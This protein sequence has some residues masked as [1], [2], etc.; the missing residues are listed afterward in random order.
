MRRVIAM[1][2]LRW[3]SS[4]LGCCGRWCSEAGVGGGR[5][6]RPGG[7]QQLPRRLRRRPR[8]PALTRSRPSP[9]SSPA[10]GTASSGT[11]TSPTRTTRACGR[12]P[13]SRRSLLDGA[14][15]LLPDAVGGRR[16]VPGRQDRRPRQ[17]ADAGTHVFEIR[18]SIPGVLDP[19]THRRRQDTS[20]R[21]PVSR[22]HRRR[23]SSGTS[24][25]RR[26]TTRSSGPTSRSRCP[27]TVT[28]RGSARSASASVGPAAT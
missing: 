24:S 5:R 23:R 19:G 18:Y 26:G 15:R 2:D 21:P 10:A 13:R 11:G 25:H 9:A 6:R 20:P 12:S 4:R 22:H 27:A 7:V 28:G 16:P 3:R 14:A 1:V 17:H 8:R